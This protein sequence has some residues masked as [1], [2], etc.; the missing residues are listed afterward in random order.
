L[1]GDAIAAPG[2]TRAAVL[3]PAAARPAAPAALPGVSAAKVARRV[4]SSRDGY[5]ISGACC[6]G[7][8][9]IAVA[10]GPGG[11]TVRE[12]FQPGAFDE[13]LRS[14]DRAWSVVELRDGHAGPVLATTSDNSLTFEVAP[15]VGLI[16]TARATSARWSAG[17][18]ADVREGRAGLSIAFR[19]QRVTFETD[20]RGA[21]VRV[22]HEAGIDHVALIRPAT[23]RPVYP[24]RCVIVRADRPHAERQ[25]RNKAIVAAARLVVSAVARG[26]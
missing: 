14:I 3:V 21:K 22:V 20:H 19:P 9:S 18:L 25:A 24:T 23:G 5:F 8:S 11:T 10:G 17:I 26:E 7:R 2:A 6:P 15:L 16:A 12:R 4:A 13:E 1:W